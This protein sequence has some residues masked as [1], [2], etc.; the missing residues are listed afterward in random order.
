VPEFEKALQTDSKNLQAQSNLASALFSLQ[1]YQEAAAAY[2]KAIELSPDDP[3]LRTNLGTALQKSGR[4]ADAKKAF[5]EADRL[6]A[7]QKKATA[8]SN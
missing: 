6:R 1:R 2:S 5:A 7:A 3:D 8:A 4:D